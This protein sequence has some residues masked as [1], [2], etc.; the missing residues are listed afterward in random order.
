MKNKLAFFLLFIALQ[1]FSQSLTIKI[2]PSDGCSPPYTDGK[3]FAVVTNLKQPIHYQWFDS[4]RVAIANDT[5]DSITNLFPDVKYYIQVSGVSS[6]ILDTLF[7]SASVPL[8][9]PLEITF[10]VTNTGCY[11]TR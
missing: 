10:S 6:T 7:D 8:K 3:L 11:D 9:D 2:E 4:K 1:T 5:T